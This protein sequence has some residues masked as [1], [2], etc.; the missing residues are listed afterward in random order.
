[1]PDPDVAAVRMEEDDHFACTTRTVFSNVF[2]L[3]PS[4]A[5]D[6]PCRARARRAGGVYFLYDKPTIERAHSDVK[7]RWSERRALLSRRDVR[8]TLNGGTCSVA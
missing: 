5:R 6:Y 7:R 2:A 1:M 4:E 8:H 3:T